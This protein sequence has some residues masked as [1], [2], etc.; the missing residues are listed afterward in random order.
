LKIVPGIVSKCRQL[1][2]DLGANFV[3]GF[4][5]ETWEELRE[6]FRF[7]ESCGFDLTHFHIATP[8]PGTE[9][10]HIAKNR[11]LLPDN[12]SFF[13]KKYFGFGQAFIS[14]DEF[15]AQELMV[16]R[17]YEYDRI[18][19]STPEKI[20]KVAEMML[21]DQEELREHRRQTRLNCGIHF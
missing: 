7:A 14:T 10:Y 13:D 21:V 8:L 3:I 16:L 5:G 17:A 11:G 20:A 9:L 1:G 15:T 2:I 18:N 19:F 6:T 12:F 4:P